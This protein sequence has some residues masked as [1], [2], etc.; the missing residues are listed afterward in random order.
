[1]LQ[2]TVKTEK[3]IR[4]IIPLSYD[5]LVRSVLPKAVKYGQFTHSISQVALT[6]LFEFCR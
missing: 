1:M 2:N 3:L 6:H 5:T 4:K